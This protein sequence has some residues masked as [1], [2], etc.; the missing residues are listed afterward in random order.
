MSYYDEMKECSQCGRKTKAKRILSEEQTQRKKKYGASK[1]QLNCPL[2]DNCEAPPE[3]HAQIGI[4]VCTLG[5]SCLYDEGH[6]GPHSYLPE[7]TFMCN[8]HPSPKGC[9]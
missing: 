6:L 4:G 8:I 1:R 2:G 9:P 5:A 3:C 7:N